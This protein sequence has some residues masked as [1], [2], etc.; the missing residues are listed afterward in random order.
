MPL[1]VLL[2]LIRKQFSPS[3]GRALVSSLQQDPLVWQFVQED[4]KSLEYFQTSQPDL[5]TFKPGNIINWLINKTANEPV[6][7]LGEIET[8]LP[9]ELKLEAAQTFETVK[10][11][12][13]APTD[14]I[15]AGLVALSLREMRLQNGGWQGISKNTIFNSHKHDTIKLLEVW[16]TPFS[17][18]FSLCPD[19]DEFVADF[20]QSDNHNILIGSVP[21]IIHAFLS[22][23]MLDQQLMDLLFG[24]FVNRSI[25]LQLEGL[26]WLENFKREDLRKTL[27]KNLMETRT[28]TDY[29]ASVF[30]DFEAFRTNTPDIDPLEKEIRYDLPEDFNRLGAFYFYIG[31][32]QKSAE[33]YQ[34]AYDLL[35]FL[36]S[37]TLFQS[38]KSQKGQI[39]SSLW[40]GLMNDV[41]NSK[42]AKYFFIQ[43]L[44]DLGKFDEA[45]EKLDFLE[46]SAE[47]QIL[48]I[49]IQKNT[50]SKATSTINAIGYNKKNKKATILAP[51]YVHK[52]KFDDTNKLLETVVSHADIKSHLD[53]IDDV[54]QVNL[55][56][57]E[58]VEKIRDIYEKS[59]NIDKAL[60]L[61]SYLERR[62]PDHNQH[63]Q[64]LARLYSK[65][66]RW[67]EAFSILQNLVKSTTTPT[68]Q[69]L[70]RFAES[71][72]RTDR[73]DIAISV[74]QNILQKES[75]NP[76]ALILLGES[77]MSK[78]DIIK[79]IQHME[80][81]VEMI[82]EEPNTWL[83]LAHL[84]EENGQ[85]DR[86]FE[87]LKKG[88]QTLPNEPKLLRRLG[89]EFLNRKSF[90]QALIHLKQANDIDPENV[91]G[92]FYLAQA[93]HLLKQYEAAWNL[94]QPFKDDYKQHP[95]IARLMGDI[96]LS[97]NKREAAEPIL[98]FSADHFPEDAETVM[99]AARLILDKHEMSFDPIPGND[100]EIVAR[101]LKK[102]SDL[103]PSYPNLKLHLADVERLKGN[104][105]KALSMYREMSP[106]DKTEK[107]TE[108]WR[109]NYGLGKTATALGEFEMGLAA[110]QDAGSS[111]PDN[112][113]ILHGLVE[114]YQKA[115]L[116]SKANDLAQA[117]LKLAP[118]DLQNILWYANFKNK[119]NEPEEAIKALKDALQID[120]HQP[121]IKL[122]LAKTF[123]L[124]GSHQEA[125]TNLND[126]ISK[127]E[128]KPEELHQTAYTCVRINELEL[129]AKAL[130][131]AIKR[132]NDFIPIFYLDLA[133]AY[134]LVDR[135]KE[136][137]ELLNIDDKLLKEFPQ[138]SL[139]KSD[140][141]SNLGQYQLA[142]RTLA[143]F[144][145]KI[146]ESLSD[147]NNNGDKT[148]LSPLLYTKDFTYAGYLFRMGQLSRV[149][150]NFELSKINLIKAADLFPENDEIKCA[151]FD[152]YIQSLDFESIK[153]ELEI[154]LN[155][156]IK[157]GALNIDKLDLVCSEIEWLISQERLD[158]AEE[159]NI[160]LSPANR[161]YPRYLA[162][163]SRLS[164]IKG[165][166]ERAKSL[167]DE[168]N[169]VY[170][171]TLTD[172]QSK[173]LNILFRKLR[174][175]ISLAVAAREQDKKLS[176]VQIHEKAWHIL[177][178]QPF[179][180]WRFAESIIDSA[181]NQQI[182]ETLSIRNHSPGKT[183]FS[184]KFQKISSLLLDNLREYLPKEDY[185]CCQA[186]ISASL[187]GEWHLN[188]NPDFCLG[189]PDKAASVILF[190]KDEKLAKKIL[191]T[192]PNHPKIL[193]AYS[194]YAFKNGKA[195]AEKYVSK[196]LE[197]DTSNP[198]NHALLAMLQEDQPEQALKSIQT[199][200]AFWQ[201]EPDW[202]AFAANLCKR[203]GDHDKASKH[204]SQ[205]IE[206]QPENADFWEES[207]EINLSINNLS[208]A[209][210][211]LEH[212][213]TLNANDTGIWLKMADVNR[214]L[215]YVNEAT[216][217]IHNAAKLNPN[218]KNIAVK[219]AQ[220]LFE[221]NQ[222]REA[223]EIAKGIIEK[224][225]NSSDA[226]ILLARSQRKQG[227]F[228]SALE[229]LEKASHEHKGN[230]EILLETLKIRRDQ[231]GTEAVLP[232][233][234]QLAHDLPEDPAVLTTLIDWL[235]QTNRLK[236][237]EETAQTILKIIPGQAQ[238]HLMLG[239][240]QRKNG[241][242]DQALSHFSDAITIDPNMIDAYIEMGKTYQDRREIDK[243][244][245][246]YQKATHADASDSRP[247]YFAG[248]AL[249]ERKD[250]M[251]A[252]AML[253]Q[254]KK[255]APNDA[256]IVRQLG[257]VTAL[258]LINN[259]R[260]AN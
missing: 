54:L 71:A 232:D 201:D 60:E 146:S 34:N 211:D 234:I 147:N 182:A 164:S 3:E 13:L 166:F 17:C 59:E 186:R 224:D 107:G 91:E 66:N 191:E 212:S 123:I 133:S 90:D 134:L 178:N 79:A 38:I 26:K 132:E 110:L 63:K 43:N 141:Q 89:K 28:N 160:K 218:D 10:N 242:L 65:K 137:L 14:L 98:L 150:G 144:G 239:R 165:D 231:E 155:D 154:N 184:E 153:K 122:E 202:H 187:S 95:H 5:E 80:Q 125:I 152:C 252:E 39:S 168:A 30:S 205:A 92:I 238:L 167:Y 36:K 172:L 31:D 25:D 163:Q 148:D 96:L 183:I 140:I 37:Q 61:T 229:T 52:A 222:F 104:F 257:M 233:L 97:M 126:L 48:D 74:C 198:I 103:N 102:S 87:I 230:K 258:N 145:E 175:L 251:G 8:T 189:S 199:A 188:L 200:L 111:Q 77:F 11:T 76:K 47:K 241:Q 33:A 247:Y 256:N 20:F 246:I 171:N 6:E 156:D 174:N 213:A 227:K 99:K 226:I 143:A 228:K 236:K 196:A 248:L 51:Y 93:N 214:R 2:D 44:I 12:G 158:E 29:F 204:I 206:N 56:D 240:L 84:W 135:P 149:L 18:L 4:E 139:V 151:K 215:G 223:E 219:E 69:D 64:N 15:S 9:D 117:S 1:E 210:Q 42:T 225:S 120:P 161:T 128:T 243:A 250:Y 185:L 127:V 254:A 129:A 94:L 75:K 179:Y 194:I 136:A 190:T 207:A 177:D 159:I 244:L 32:D 73:V 203:I 106:K 86:S 78:G 115:N 85:I 121:K 24:L 46:N 193:Q 173:D 157:K 83:T 55:N 119:N 19:F 245:E 21:I 259:L 82:P 197:F 101:I 249:K 260:E 192:Y 112:L 57:L 105:D 208:G 130:E 209:K 131:E 124:I 114:A 81:V 169:E 181:E 45:A 108:D 35:N 195:E 16:R 235:I 70:E 50:D 237:A 67:D 109:L 138:L 170:Q 216:K 220:F 68:T 58:I 40:M 162:I 100:L 142:Y 72:L 180:N 27:A 116:S 221:T 217:N 118:R 253:R 7:N 62:E 22:N 255:Y 88:A 53:M 176:A 23:A 49:Q 41:P 113:L